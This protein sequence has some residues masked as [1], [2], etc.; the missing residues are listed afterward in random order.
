MQLDYEYDY[1][2]GWLIHQVVS[3]TGGEHGLG[4]E[5]QLEEEGGGG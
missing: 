3:R 1:F 4:M 2:S 5:G